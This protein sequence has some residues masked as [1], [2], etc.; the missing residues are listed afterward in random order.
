MNAAQQEQKR[1]LS[2]LWAVREVD[3]LFSRFKRYTVFVLYGKWSLVGFAAVLMIALIAWPF[4]TKDQSGIRVSFVDNKTV[5][6]TP[7]SPVM[8]N[9]EYRGVGNNGT[10]Y[11]VNGIRATQM[12]GN[13]ILIEKVEAQMLKGGGGWYSLTADK[14]E[15]HQNE[16][17]LELTGN[18]TVIDS[19]ANNFITERATVN[20]LTMDMRGDAPVTGTSPRGNILASGFEI[21][22]NGNHITFVRGADPLTVEIEKSPR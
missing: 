8:S 13:V 22:D 4:I 10:Q 15:F 2:N 11:K 12:G 21:R 5:G 3:H 7:S 19:A 17:R 1:G 18:V 14:A 6:G 16:N 9:P 20:T